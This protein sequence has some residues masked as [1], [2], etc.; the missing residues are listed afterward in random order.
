MSQSGGFSR[1]LNLSQ[2]SAASYLTMQSCQVGICNTRWCAFVMSLTCGQSVAHCCGVLSLPPTKDGQAL[3]SD[4]S[5]L[6]C[7][8]MFF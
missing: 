3:H 4:A 5:R 8:Q 6:E 2:N 1:E 7:C